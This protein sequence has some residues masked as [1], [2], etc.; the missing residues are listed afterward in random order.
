M[1]DNKYILSVFYHEL[2]GRNGQ[3]GVVEKTVSFSSDPSTKE[4]FFVKVPQWIVRELLKNPES[5]EIENR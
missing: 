5:F 3:L 1:E 2:V 4:A